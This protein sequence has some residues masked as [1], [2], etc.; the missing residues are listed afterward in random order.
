MSHKKDKKRAAQ[1]EVLRDGKISKLSRCPVPN[2]SRG[3]ITGNSAHGLCPYHEEFLASMLFF[4]P[5]IRI[6]Q[7][8]TPGGLVLP[9]QP[10]FQAVPESVIKAEI[11]KHGRI[12]P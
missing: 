2:C 4:L 3:I 12:K 8:K 5:R 10:G 9:G 7:A 1:G 11:E 6:D